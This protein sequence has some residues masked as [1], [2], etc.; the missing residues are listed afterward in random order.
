MIEYRKIA[1]FSYKGNTY[2]LLVDKD[3]KYFFL[4]IDSDGVYSYVSMDEYMAFINIFCRKPSTM[5]ITDEKTGRKSKRL[6]VVPKVILGTTAVVLSATV[7]TTAINDAKYDKIVA[8]YAKN[9]GDSEYVENSIQKHVSFLVE[10]S[11]EE[12][13]VD[14]KLDSAFNDDVYIF[15]MEYLDDYL[16]YKTASKEMLLNALNNNTKIGG[17]YK[18]LMTEFIDNLCEKYPDV[19]KRVLYENLKGLEV[20]ECSKDELMMKT[21]N[22]DSCACYVRNENKIYT[23]KDYKYEK[24]TWEYQ[25]IFHEMG[26]ALTC[27]NIKVGDKML[28]VTN[29]GDALSLVTVDEALNSVFAVSLFDYEERDIA[30]QLQSN[31]CSIMVECL[32]NY[33]LADYVDHSLSYYAKKLDEHN[34]DNNYAVTMLNLIDTQYK[35]YHSD[36]IEIE[37]EEYYPIY[38]YVADMYYMKYITPGMSYGEAKQIADTLVDRVMFDVPEEYNIDTNRFYVDLDKHCELVGIPVVNN[39]RSM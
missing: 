11:Q 36:E 19:D 3:N 10:D 39:S 30:Y 5:M 8:E 29:S 27:G 2:Q 16:D 32:D 25:I 9:M 4:K 26:H 6:K 22:V 37:Q 21:L 1:K 13:V 31:Y 33:S 38:D 14:T 34:G 20:V 17:Q 7:I 24:G 28:K 12:L 35:D 23:L 15:D 18:I